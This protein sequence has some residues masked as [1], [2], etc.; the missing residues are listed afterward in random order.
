MITK[1][2]ALILNPLDGTGSDFLFSVPQTWSGSIPY[3]AELREGNTVLDSITQTLRI[4]P[5]PIIE[6]TF[7]SVHIFTGNTLTI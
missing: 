7:R 1:Q 2:S 3:T 6:N 5:I 4:A